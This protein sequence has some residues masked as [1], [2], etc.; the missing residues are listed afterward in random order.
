MSYII[1]TAQLSKQIGSQRIIESIDLHVQQ[2]EIY[3]LLGTNSAGKTALLRLLTGQLLPSSGEIAMFG[4]ALKGH[5]PAILKRIGIL[6]AQPAFYDQL[7]VNDN[8]ELH[9]RYMGYYQRKASSEILQALKLETQQQSLV[10]DLDLASKQRLAIARAII[11][12]PELLLLDEPNKGLDPLATRDIHQLLLQ[13]TQEYGTTI[14]FTSHS[15]SEIELLA[16]TIGI[17]KQGRLLQELP[18][19]QIQQTASSYIEISTEQASRACL[20]LEQQLQITSFRLHHDQQI[21]IYQ[22]QQQAAQIL[23]TLV[24][25][26]VPI[27]AF[28]Q[29]RQTLEDHVFDLLNKN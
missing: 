19:K 11:T 13:L 1:Q 14:L 2:G 5:T 26:D 20:I 15:L 9:M 27:D 24:M 25:H 3:G 12:R 28:R 16:D 8:L 18:I 29:H 6:I 4:Q 22:Q 7:S 17:L 10:R 23:K 21:R